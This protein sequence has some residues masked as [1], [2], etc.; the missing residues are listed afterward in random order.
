MTAR[1]V[2]APLRAASL[3]L[4]AVIGC[5][6]A[7][8]TSPPLVGPTGSTPAATPAGRSPSPAAPSSDAGRAWVA[9]PDNPDLQGAFVGSLTTV[10]PDLL[11]ASGYVG[12]GEGRVDG[13]IWA[14]RDGRAWTRLTDRAGFEDAAVGEIIQG[15]FGGFLAVGST[16]H[17]E[18]AGVRMWRSADGAVWT[19]VAHDLPDSS[20]VN[21]IPGGPRWV[22]VGEVGL[23]DGTLAAWASPDGATWLEATG[24]GAEPGVIRG[25][26]ATADGFLTAG[27][28]YPGV[29]SEPAVWMSTDAAVWAR[30]PP[31]DGP[32]GLG[33]DALSQLNGVL[34]TFVRTESGIE[35]WTST[36]GRDW[37]VDSDA[38][39]VFETGGTRSLRMTIV[40]Q[41]G[42]GLVAFAVA[43]TGQNSAPIGVWLSADGMAWQ[44]ADDVSVFPDNA[45][46]YDGTSFGGEVL[47]VGRVPCSQEGCVERPTF[48]VSPPR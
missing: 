7:V 17:F 11:L 6:V 48:W 39:A 12:R 15:R 25:L 23:P 3:A 2:G 30:V 36:D 4:M 31:V 43:D 28:V 8:P 14:S 13:A 5:S 27:S 10:G 16:C 20:F 42:P 9:L 18:C 1:G 35:P 21:V 34:T 29:D 40:V 19:P 41:G 24:M 32:Q 46:I 47:V 33:I 26:V 37:D 22:A 45:E 38:S 44:A